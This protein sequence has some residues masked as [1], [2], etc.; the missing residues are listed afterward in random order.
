LSEKKKKKKTKKKKKKKKKK[1]KKKN[2]QG[3]PSNGSMGN[4]KLHTA[5]PLLSPDYV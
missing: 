2:Q 3:T 1:Q 4:K 5:T